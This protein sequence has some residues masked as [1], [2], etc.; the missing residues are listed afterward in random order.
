LILALIIGVLW[1]FIINLGGFHIK[2][3]HLLRLVRYPPVWV[4]GIIG[5]ILY[6]LITQH[7]IELLGKIGVK[8]FFLLISPILF[9][10]IIATLL[11]AL[12]GHKS[13]RLSNQSD[14]LN[15]QSFGNIVKDPKQLLLWIEDESPIWNPHQD[16]FG[17]ARI[18]RRISNILLARYTKTVGVVGT[19]G[20]GK[21]SLLNIVEYYL[22]NRNEL[23]PKGSAESDAG[24]G[25]SFKGQTVICHID[26]WGRSKGSVDQ[27]ILSI[28]VNRLKNEVDCLSVA[29]VPTNYRKALEG[30][31][32]TWAAVISSLFHTSCDPIEQ[33][34]KLDEILCAA[35][36]RLIIFL[37]DVDRNIDDRII[38]DELPSLLD[39]LRSLRNV[40]FV[41]A[42]GTERQYSNI[43]IRICDH[44]ETIA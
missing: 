2:H 38:R 35:D 26:G 15:Y 32:S 8:E 29:T 39:R 19:Y 43:L 4:A 33:V 42:I 12:F 44:V 10:V 20:S 9:G 1:F 16:L 5:S 14:S 37:E 13:R 3:L 40:S 24:K 36:L 27:Q 34:E 23:E 30:V 6:L 11:S 28:A 18:A 22:N 25:I 31:K 7:N 17:L 21:S 41:L